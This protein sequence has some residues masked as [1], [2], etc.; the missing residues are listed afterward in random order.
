M[1]NRPCFLP[2]TLHSSSTDSTADSSN[3]SI[4]PIGK[5]SGKLLY[6]QGVDWEGTATI[7]ASKP[8]TLALRTALRDSMRCPFDEILGFRVFMLL[9][10]GVA[11]YRLVA[12]CKKAV[13]LVQFLQLRDVELFITSRR[14]VLV[15]FDLKQGMG[16]S[17]AAG[18]EQNNGD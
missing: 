9:R 15:L 3:G 8:G 17:K 12:R 11:R 7:F 2:S 18:D 14:I 4:R 10:R 13:Y 6:L 5:L 16:K 1:L